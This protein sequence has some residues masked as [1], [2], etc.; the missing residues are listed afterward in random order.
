MFLLD[1]LDY[2]LKK[3]K[4]HSAN[5]LTLIN[6][7]LGTFA[8]IS[9]FHHE[10]RLSLFLIFLAAF[11]DRFD[12][13]VARKFGVESEFGKQLDS[14]CDIISF[15]IAPALLVYQGVLHEYGT[16][17]TLFTIFYVACSA[18]RLA[19]FNISEN[20][21]Y[22]TGLPITAAGCLITFSFLFHKMIPGHL[23]MFLVVILSVLM[24]SNFKLK[25]V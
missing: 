14:M 23:F 21:G 13:M 3:L 16:P 20:N 12:G 2:T 1:Y 10:F 8:L 4:A 9:I 25:K 11:A 5:C 15:G 19:R 18:M 22:F 24:I 17:G 7:S 6:L